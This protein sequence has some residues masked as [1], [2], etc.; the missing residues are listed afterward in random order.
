MMSLCTCKINNG[1]GCSA[2]AAHNYKISSHERCFKC[3]N[4]SS[5]VGSIQECLSVVLIFVADVNQ[6]AVITVLARH[7][8]Q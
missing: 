7:V 8:L 3:R 2:G 1:R 5:S 6:S 4:S